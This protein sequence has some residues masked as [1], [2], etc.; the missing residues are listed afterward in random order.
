MKKAVM[1]GSVLRKFAGKM[2]S[3]LSCY[4]VLVMFGSGC[5][6]KVNTAY[7]A[8]APFE[9]Y[10]R[11]CW[12]D[13]CQ[14]T[15]DAPEYIKTDS[16]TVEI[17]KDA[18]VQELKGKGYIYDANNPDFLLYMHIVMEEKQTLLVSPYTQGD[19]EDWQGAFPIGD[20][21]SRTYTYLKGSMVIDIAD[22]T[23]SRMVWRSDVVEYLDLV[24]DVTES[25][26]RKGV[27]KALKEFPPETIQRPQ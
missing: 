4:V 23:E 2:L 27:K 1:H 3:I 17:Y 9:T 11:F 16:A 7:D 26:L 12:F 24:T 10:E 21:P 22:A 14:F 6:L 13:N 19:P 18:I 25:R 15:I 20:S 5:A 8:S